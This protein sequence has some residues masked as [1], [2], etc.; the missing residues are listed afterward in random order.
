MYI[1]SDIELGRCEMDMGKNTQAYYGYELRK[2]SYA[3]YQ[4]KLKK[5][6][7]QK[8]LFSRLSS[9]IHQLKLSLCQFVEAFF[10]PEVISVFGIIGMILFLLAS[11]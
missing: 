1:Y 7:V 9:C 6:A 11:S 8:E 4:H 3:E 5:K 2:C 10:S